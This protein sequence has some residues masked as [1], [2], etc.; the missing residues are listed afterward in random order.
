MPWILRLLIYVTCFFILEFY[1]F[2][3]LFNSIRILYPN[4]LKPKHK[5]LLIIVI[6]LL[7]LF[8]ITQFLNW[9]L[10]LLFGIELF[11]FGH[12]FIESI[13]IHYPF[14]INILIVLQSSVLLLPVDLIRLILHPFL[15]KYRENIKVWNARLILLVYIFFLVYVPLRIYYDINFVDVRYTEYKTAKLNKSLQGFKIGLIADIQA[16]YYTDEQ[17]IKNY[18]DKLNQ[19]EP[20]LVLIAG[21]VITNSAD[22]IPVAADALSK[23]K[24]KYGIYASVGDHDNWAYG[25]N[26]M[27][28][29]REVVET[30]DKKG[31][32]MLDDV[33]Y[34]LKIDSAV[35]G[36]TFITDTYSDRIS[37]SL[38]DSLT[39]NL[40]GSDL[41]ILLSHQPNYK[42]V[43]RAID[44][45]YNLM[46]SGH[47][48]GGQI[49]ILFPFINLSPTI[50]ETKYVRGDFWFGNTL[51]V[52]C[53]G[54]GFSIAP[55]RFNSTPEIVIIELEELQD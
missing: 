17:R 9:S 14:W 3:K 45:K 53:R 42:I 35:I 24:S 54:L 47:T 18:I 52:V 10:E 4:A 8:P 25:R 37:T 7:N 16:D 39:S 19:A 29:R 11:D 20:D 13:L 28:S 51:L 6:L 23:I 32:Y 33:N 1:F 44:N 38:L 5:R 41:R 31:I 26:I 15:K 46:L 21:D 12:S 27:K 34:K 50:F 2:K 43:Q 48:H 55:V 40:H 22:Y 49:T 30:L 36:I